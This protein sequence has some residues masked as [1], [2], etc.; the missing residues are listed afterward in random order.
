M[1]PRHLH[2]LMSLLGGLALALAGCSDGTSII[3]PEP[4]EPVLELPPLGYVGSQSCQSCHQAEF[5]KWQLSGHPWKLMKIKNAQPPQLPFGAAPLPAGYTWD[6]IT[7]VI[8]GFGWKSRYVGKDGYIITAGGKNQF[9]LNTQD[10]SDYNKDRSTKYDCGSCHTT[11]YSPLGHQDGLPGI[12]GTWKEEGVGC[13]ACHGQGS[14]HAAAPKQ[15]RLQSD[16]SLRACATCHNRGGIHDGITAQNGFLMHRDAYHALRN[17][18]HLAYGCTT[19]HDPHAGAL[20]AEEKGLPSTRASCESCHRAARASL[21]QGG[22]GAAKGDSPCVDCH[23]PMMGVSGVP[24]PNRKFTG[25]LRTHIMRINTDTAAVQF[26]TNGTRSNPF[27]TLDFA[28]ITCHQD[29]D[30]A[31]AAQWSKRIHKK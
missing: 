11:G 25:D 28:C 8:G 6:D 23:M 18:A 31:W 29:Q 27:I 2:C 19:C 13:E 26:H 9:N 14:Q 17:N 16:G 12:V 24:D 5:A 22:L 4:V 21:Q 10:W 20:Y 7:Y 3:E 1:K 15:V 30:R